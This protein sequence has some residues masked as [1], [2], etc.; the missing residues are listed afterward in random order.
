MIDCNFIEK[1]GKYVCEVCGFTIGVPNVHRNCPK[2]NAPNVIQKAQNFTKAVANHVAKGRPK[3]TQEE[4]D[5]RLEVCKTC[6]LFQKFSE[7]KG[8]CTHSSCGCNIARERKFLNKLAWA[9]QKCPI[10]KWGPIEK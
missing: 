2:A 1:D 7:D 5:Q 6:E 9:D 3:C 8:V 10:G 4:I